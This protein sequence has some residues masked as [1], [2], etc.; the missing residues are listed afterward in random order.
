[1]STSRQSAVEPSHVDAIDA[2]V[3]ETDRP[4]EEVA[5][6]YMRELTRLREGARIQ[7]YLVLLTSRHV[8]QALRRSGRGRSLEPFGSIRTTDLAQA[9]SGTPM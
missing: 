5:E 3:V 6:I 9:A 4:V 7:D 2:L 8:R 1:M